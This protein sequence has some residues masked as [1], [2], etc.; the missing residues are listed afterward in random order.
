MSS[1]QNKTAVIT[2]GNSGIGYAAAEELAAQGANVVIT[3]RDKESIANTSSALK[4][5]GIVSDQSDLKA[6]DQL[7]ADVKAKFGSVDILFVNAGIAPFTPIE[8]ASEDHYD[9]VMNINVKGVYFTIQKFLPIL[10]EGASIIFNSSVIAHLG[11]PNSSVYAA[12][13]A[14]LL[15]INRVLATELA[16]RKIRVNAISPGPI[17]TPIYGKVG[18]S[19]EEIEGFGTIL[20]QK[21][22]L[23]RFGKPQEIAKAV[24]FLASD[25]SSF[26]TGTEI[27][28]DGGIS[29]NAIVS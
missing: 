2:G 14:A 5:T 19:Q 18:L 22:L 13:K 1:L 9:S 23:K 11:M 12:S 28:V 17:E 26:I 16:P 4:V 25:D 27:V 3:G 29:V 8:H 10:N 20:G 24:K 15:A 21:I 7:V 6:I